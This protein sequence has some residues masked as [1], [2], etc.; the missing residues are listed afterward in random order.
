MSAV[1][2]FT[3]RFRR[4]AES[5]APAW[6]NEIARL[7]ALPRYQPTET[8]L[9][10][11]SL[12]LVD[13]ASF[14]A[15]YR[16]IFDEEIYK[17]ASRSSNPLILDCGANIG[18]GEIYWKRLYPAARIIAFEPDPVVFE[19]LS[20]NCSQRQLRN[21]ELVSKAVWN[22][23]GEVSFLS[24]GADAGHVALGNLRD[25]RQT[26]Q[27][28]SV[29]LRDYLSEPIE[30]LKLDIEGAEFEV[31]SDCQ[32]NLEN[33]K[34]LFVEYHS[35]LGQEQRLDEIF[36]IL[37]RNGF[38]IH[39]KSQLVTPMPFVDRLNYLGLDNSLNIFAYRD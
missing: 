14:L 27:V 37:K 25:V 26:I 24:E 30:L 11:E 5:E 19:T 9:F 16:E 18:L 7:Q 21:V 22:G 13:A 8:K 34:H 32:N 29:R 39:V 33:V 1:G 15:S 20:W 35:F 6:R 4:P 23:P 28:P 36:S 38:R 31:L 17:F 2:R 3:S 12:R 10:G